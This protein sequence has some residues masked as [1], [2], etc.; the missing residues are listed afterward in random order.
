MN[1]WN[2]I[3]A[4]PD[5]PD[6]V[7]A[8]IEVPKGSR[9]KYEYDKDKEAFILDRVLYSPVF[10][11]ADYGFIPRSL[12]H[13]GDPMDVLV[14]IEQPTFSG[15]LVDVRPIGVM[16]MI[17]GGDND[18]KILAVPVNDP[19][20]DEVNDISDVPKHLLK[21]I[22]HFF[23]VYKHLEGKDV[24][25]LGWQDA[26]AAKKEIIESLDLFIKKYD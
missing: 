13:D 19:R 3:D 17:D 25:T 14:L 11:P 22:E 9:N 1:L 7:T 26:E 2:E 16:G 5:V 24:K 18:Y 15:C 10:Y 12:Y 21:E 6:I 8:V 23:S 4:G 20:Y